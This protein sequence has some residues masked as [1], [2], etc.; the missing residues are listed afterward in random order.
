M[1]GSEG[2]RMT[3]DFGLGGGLYC[4]QSPDGR[5]EG[6]SSAMV[7]WL[8]LVCRLLVG[9]LKLLFTA[10]FIREVLLRNVRGGEG[11]L[12]DGDGR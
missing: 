10:R 8:G 3:F 7:L 5:R 9:V 12:L 1:A 4:R 2:R 6:V 11:C